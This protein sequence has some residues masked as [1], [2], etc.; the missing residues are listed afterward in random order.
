MKDSISSI[1][2]NW[3]ILVI[4]FIIG[5]NNNHYNFSKKNILDLIKVIKNLKDRYYNFYFLI[6]GSRRTG[7][8]MIQILQKELAK[9]AHIWNG[10]DENPY[11]FALKY[12]KF[13]IVT[14]DSTSMISECA[15]TGKPVYVYHLPFKRRSKRIQNFHK[16]FENRKITKKFS[17]YVNLVEWKYETLDEAKR[18]SGILKER[19]LE[20]RNESR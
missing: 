6:I 3:H 9:I 13:F 12:S 4:S 19:I 7:K 16:E 11:I 15:F 10:K 18:I 1:F 17:D 20:G 5:G 8:N 14:S 2:A